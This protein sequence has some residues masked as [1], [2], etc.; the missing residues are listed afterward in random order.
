MSRSKE[1]ARPVCERDARHACNGDDSLSHGYPKGALRGFC[2]A[3]WGLWAFV[4]A[5]GLAT[6]AV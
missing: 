6:G 2:A 4:L 5:S 1:E 3:W